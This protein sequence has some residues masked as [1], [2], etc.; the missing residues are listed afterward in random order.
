[1][2]VDYDEDMDVLY[3]SFG[4]PKAAICVEVN[5][6]D[7]IRVDAYTDKIL[8]ITIVDF[9]KR[10]MES[11]TLDITETASKIIPGILTQIK[12]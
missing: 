3:I 6:G 12:Q 11:S 7:L 9:K 10:Y 4:K 8:G 1:M 5:N 2:N